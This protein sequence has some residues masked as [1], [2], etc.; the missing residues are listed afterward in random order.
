MT[1]RQQEDE[2]TRG[3][4]DKVSSNKTARSEKIEA[5]LISTRSI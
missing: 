3:Q 4:G 5:Y 1:R 2:R